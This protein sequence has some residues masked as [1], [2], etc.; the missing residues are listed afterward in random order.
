[1]LPTG[2]IIFAAHAQIL[3]QQ[4]RHVVHKVF[5][6]RRC[7]EDMLIAILFHEDGESLSDRIAKYTTALAW[8]LQHLFHVSHCTTCIP[9]LE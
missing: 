3:Q 1:M 6:H 9:V 7:S 8:M 5:N 4:C 2:M